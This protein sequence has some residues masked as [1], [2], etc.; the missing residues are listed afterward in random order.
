[1]ELR[2]QTK[3][4]SNQLQQEEFLKLSKSERVR[5]FFSLVEQLRKFPTKNKNDKSSNFNIVIQLN[6]K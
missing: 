1:M 6:D 2:F 4:K 3:E 5:Q